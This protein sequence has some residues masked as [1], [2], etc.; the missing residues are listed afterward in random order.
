M[1][2]T[3]S[4]QPAGRQLVEEHQR[5]AARQQVAAVGAAVIARL[6]RRGDALGEHRRANRHAGAERLAE[7][8]QVRLQAERAASRTRRPVRPRPHCTSSAMSSAPVR[9]HAA[10]MASAAR[11]EIGRTP[12]SPWIGST[13]T[14]A[15][16]AVIAAAMA[17][18]VGRIDERRRRARAARTARDSDRPTSPTRAPIV[19]PWNECS[20]ATN[21]V[22]GVPCA[23]QKRRENFR[24]ASTASAP[25]LQ[26]NARGSPESSD[27]RAASSDCSGWWNR[28]DVCSSVD[29]CSAIA[30]AS[31]GCAWPSDAT[32]TPEIRSR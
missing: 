4:H 10:A 2:A 11:C 15:V 20:N 32:P 17:D 19:R 23:C 5:G 14:A 6:R 21:C 31:P 3:C 8:H 12:P 13:M 9:R 29:A 24:H 16:S 22:R 18:G 7:R 28:F 30:R 1:R 27:R 26:K 25:L